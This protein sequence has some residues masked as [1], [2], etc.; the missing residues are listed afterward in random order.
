MEQIE[1]GR[2]GDDDAVL[3]LTKAI[4]EI[5]RVGTGRRRVSVVTG[6][7]LRCLVEQTLQ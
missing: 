4:D 6:Q 3:W 5:I 2:I 1:T 7:S